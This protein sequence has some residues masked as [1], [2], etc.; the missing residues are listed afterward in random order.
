M[1][2]KEQSSKQ[3]ITRNFEVDN[4]GY[5]YEIEA[6][7]SYVEMKIY[8]SSKKDL[9]DGSILEE[10]G[11]FPIGVITLKDGVRKMFIEGDVGEHISVFKEFVK[12][13]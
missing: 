10:K 1:E 7:G 8:P 6:Y 4:N 13:L 2:F 9:G 12:T 11:S 5:R 3:V